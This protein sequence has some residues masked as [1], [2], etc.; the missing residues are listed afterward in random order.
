MGRMGGWVAGFGVEKP[1]RERWASAKAEETEADKKPVTGNRLRQ[2]SKGGCL[3]APQALACHYP[4][5]HIGNCT[6]R[7]VL[8]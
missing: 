8:G 2:S 1:H 3:A 4:A 6:R 7:N 5:S